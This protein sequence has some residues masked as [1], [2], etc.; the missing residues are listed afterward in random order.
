[1]FLFSN[2]ISEISPIYLPFEIH[3]EALLICIIASFL[4]TNF[5]KYRPEFQKLL[6][7]TGPI[8]YVAFFTLTG[9]M[10]SIDIL[11]RVWTIALIFFGIRLL[12][13]IIGAYFSAIMAG[14]PPIYKKIGWM[15]YVTQAG[16][17]LGLA[18]E[19]AGE[20][21]DWGA[22][23]ATIIVAVIVLNQFIGPPLFKWAIN[24]VKEAHV[25]AETPKFDGIRD[26]I[27]FGLEDQSLALSRQ[28]KKH[29][30]RVKI[31]SLKNLKF[32]TCGI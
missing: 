10:L 14:D 28:L 11:A 12:A 6:N 13:I 1:M 26:A 18:T 4:L 27:I 29:G 32:T 24:L 22:E 20:F 25:R 21:N 17:G 9:A 2:Y 8:I 3:I 19:V 7:D 30:W 15:P 31:A 16:I 23:F 5:S